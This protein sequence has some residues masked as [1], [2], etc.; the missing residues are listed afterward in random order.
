MYKQ[1][2]ETVLNFFQFSEKLKDYDYRSTVIIN[3]RKGSIITDVTNTFGSE[4]KVNESVIENAVSKNYKYQTV[5]GCNLDKCDK[6]SSFCVQPSFGLPECSCKQG[7]YKNTQ[8][9]MKCLE[10]CKSKCKGENQLCVPEAGSNGF[11]CECQPGYQNNNGKCDSCPYGY[12][13]RNCEDGYLLAIIVT[14]V[15]A[16][17]VILALGISL[18][19]TYVRMTRAE[20]D[21]QEQHL[22]NS[23]S[24]KV[25]GVSGQP[26]RIPRVNLALNHVY[27]N[28]NSQSAPWSRTQPDE[29]DFAQRSWDRFQNQDQKYDYGKSE[30]M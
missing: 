7:F 2:F 16:A 30:H 25:N 14:G 27:Q 1:C 12:A 22:I 8:Y 10:T 21:E 24:E 19:C 4:S 13:G 18:A 11:V 17:V 5:P 9:D 23:D 20:S 29:G 3:A 6:I 26:H 28:A 15:V